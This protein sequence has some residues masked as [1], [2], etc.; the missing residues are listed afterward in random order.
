LDNTELTTTRVSDYV[1]VSRSKIVEVLILPFCRVEKLKDPVALDVNGLD[2][3]Q[4]VVRPLI[5]VRMR[6]SVFRKLDA[7]AVPNF[8][9]QNIR[10]K[11]GRKDFP[12]LPIRGLW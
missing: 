7:G 8:A 10:N 12:V 5:G 4:L 1:S 2:K 3:D 6:G 11:R 9:E